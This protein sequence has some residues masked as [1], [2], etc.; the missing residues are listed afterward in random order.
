MWPQN[1]LW[2]KQRKA[3]A[4]PNK[5]KWAVW[6]NG[7]R[8]RHAMPGSRQT[9]A[10][11]AKIPAL[12]G[13]FVHNRIEQALTKRLRRLDHMGLPPDLMMKG[14]VLMHL[15]RGCLCLFALPSALTW[16]WNLKLTSF[17]QRLREVSFLLDP[18]TSTVFYSPPPTGQMSGNQRTLAEWDQSTI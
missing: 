11:S 14:D 9:D 1:F 2:W 15:T 10:W 17:Y 7:L 6:T 12:W 8:M 3:T 16:A 18:Q 4:Q 13:A 5:Q